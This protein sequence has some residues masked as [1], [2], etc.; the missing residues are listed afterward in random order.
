[1]TNVNGGKLPD[2]NLSNANYQD[3]N[4]TSTQFGQADLRD[5]TGQPL[6]ASSASY[7]F[8]TCPKGVMSTDAGNT[9]VGQG[10]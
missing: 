7:V 4:L 9:C 6:N 5:A 3:A 2:A 1:L 8:T 10:F